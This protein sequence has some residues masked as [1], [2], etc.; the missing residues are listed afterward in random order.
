ML[1]KGRVLA[2]VAAFA[3]IA[4][5][6]GANAQ[7]GLIG[8]AFEDNDTAITKVEYYYSD[9][10]EDRYYHED[11]PLILPFA[12]LGGVAGLVHGVLSSVFDD[13]YYCDRPY[14]VSAYYGS[15]YYRDAYDDRSYDDRRY[16]RDDYYIDARYGD[17][18]RPYRYRARYSE[19]QR[20]IGY[21]YTYYYPD[22]RR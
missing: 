6:T 13:D 16:G 17:D 5:F 4:A 22:D 8:L 11:S 2:A 18:E 21:D 12:V 1:S 14:Y 19:Y 10:Y 15:P 7:P 3:A 9:R 20:N